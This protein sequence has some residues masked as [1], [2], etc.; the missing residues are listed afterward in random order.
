MAGPVG[1]GG[2]GMEYR[3]G[4]LYFAVLLKRRVYVLDPK[5]WQMQT[6]WQVAGARSH[7]VGWGGR[8]T[9]GR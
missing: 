5:T 6:M 1:E 7:S 9:L 2:Q 3:D 4:P 8:Y